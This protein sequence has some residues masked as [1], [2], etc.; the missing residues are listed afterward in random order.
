MVLRTQTVSVCRQVLFSPDF[1]SKS[2]DLHISGDT[3]V[4]IESPFALQLCSVQGFNSL[5]RDQKS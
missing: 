3:S 1:Y 2:I 5:Q 4:T